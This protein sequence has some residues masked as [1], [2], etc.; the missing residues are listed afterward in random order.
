M[1]FLSRLAR[2]NFLPALAFGLFL[3]R[4]DRAAKTARRELREKSFWFNARGCQKS[5]NSFLVQK[6]AEVGIGNMR[7]CLFHQGR[8]SRMSFAISCDL[9]ELDKTVHKLNSEKCFFLVTSAVVC[10][11]WRTACKK[12]KGR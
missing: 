3:G 8:V 12:R 4:H 1:H 11:V 10:A 7:T 9:L 6:E 5:T 2:G